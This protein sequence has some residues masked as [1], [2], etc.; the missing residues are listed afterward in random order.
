[1]EEKVQETSLVVA[2]LADV[3]GAV[4]G[5][6]VPA[7]GVGVVLGVGAAGDRLGHHVLGHQLGRLFELVRERQFLVELAGHGFGLPGF[8]GQLVPSATGRPPT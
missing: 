5:L 2:D 6:E 3:D 8:E 4:P 7:H 1:M